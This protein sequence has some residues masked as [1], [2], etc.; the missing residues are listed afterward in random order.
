MG[1]RRLIGILLLYY[2]NGKRRKEKA[3]G[4]VWSARARIASRA[5]T[6]QRVIN[7]LVLITASPTPPLYFRHH[8]FTFRRRTGAQS[9]GPR[10]KNQAFQRH[11][12]LLFAGTKEDTARGLGGP[13]PPQLSGINIGYFPIYRAFSRV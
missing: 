5:I 1:D 2:G 10:L 8:E 3:G 4:F 13:R 9:A 11:A 6:M 12:R 7:I